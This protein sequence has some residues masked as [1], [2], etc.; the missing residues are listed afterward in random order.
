L[1][2]LI[3]VLG[4]AVVAATPAQAATVSVA[5]QND[6]FSP[7]TVTAAQG[8][9]VRWTQK[10]QVVLH[11]STSDQG[12]WHSPDLS[13]GQTYSQTAAFKNAGSYAYHCKFHVMFGMVGTV[14]VPLKASGSASTGWTLR[15]SSLASTPSSRAF[16][17]QIKRPGSTTWAKFRTDT[18]TRNAFF[19]PSKTGTY[20][21]RARTRNLT[22]AKS[23][24]WSPVRSLKIT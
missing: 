21:F 12:F 9:T 6:M 15:W 7:K 23:S 18:A 13:F 19:N 24:G 2:V 3:S 4:G 16:D 8:S 5:M 10:D 22:N 1:L 20:A 11:T 14:R 17:V